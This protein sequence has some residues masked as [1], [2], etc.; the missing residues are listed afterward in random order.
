MDIIGHLHMLAILVPGKASQKPIKEEEEEEITEP[1]SQSEHSKRRKK[2][3][4]PAKNQTKIPQ[5]S[6]PQPSH[7]T[8]YAILAISITYK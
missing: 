4:G 3:F 5:P 1:Q 6:S 7:Y 2:S 8:E